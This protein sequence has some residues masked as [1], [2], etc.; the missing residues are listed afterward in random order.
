[1]LQHGEKQFQ[2]GRVLSYD[3]LRREA[4]PRWNQLKKVDRDAYIK[5]IKENPLLRDEIITKIS[6]IHSHDAKIA[7]K[8][9]ATK[10][11]KDQAIKQFLIQKFKVN[12]G[13]WNRWKLTSPKPFPFN[14]LD[15]KSEAFIL[16]DVNIYL[17]TK[18]DIYPV[19]LALSKFSLSRGLL[20]TLHFHIDMDLNEDLEKG[21]LNKVK[22]TS[23]D[24]H[25]ISISEPRKGVLLRI[26]QAEAKKRVQS[27]LMGTSIAF[28]LQELMLKYDVE[29]AIEQSF[30]KA[31]DMDVKV[32]S[33]Q[34]LLMAMKRRVGDERYGEKEGL[35]AILVKNPL[36][37]LSS[38]GCMHH[39]ELDTPLFC[40]LAR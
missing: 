2:A 9:R 30:Q 1:M 25:Q 8:M 26:S 19:E 12:D 27:F 15:W 39:F 7:E 23:E 32:E 34:Q 17:K 14:T 21:L 11:A 4:L 10:I 5:A 13:K 29:E 31:F 33:I 28:T 37:Y 18:D 22:D 16:A 24:T 35:H 20:E 38:F 40:S 6:N 36:N 3:E